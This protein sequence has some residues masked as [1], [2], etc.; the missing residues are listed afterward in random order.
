ME[1]GSCDEYDF[2][3]DM[4]YATTFGYSYSAGCGCSQTG[5]ELQPPRVT[6]C[7]SVWVTSGRR[8]G[9]DAVDVSAPPAV[10]ARADDDGADAV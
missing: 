8:Y 9:V 3:L 5:G 7:A 6:D 1:S 10:L 4:D 2:F